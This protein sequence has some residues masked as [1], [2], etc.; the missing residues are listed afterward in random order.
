MNLYLDEYNS[1]V[2]SSGR[3]ISHIRDINDFFNDNSNSSS[4]INNKMP[5]PGSGGV[6]NTMGGGTGMIVGVNN[7]MRLRS[8]STVSEKNLR[9]KSH[10]ML[11]LDH[12]KASTLRRLSSSTSQQQSQQQQQQHHQQQQL[13]QQRHD[14]PVQTIRQQQAANMIDPMAAGANKMFDLP[15]GGAARVNSTTC[16]RRRYRD[17]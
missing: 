14:V 12:N 8:P 4:D 15:P 16:Q 9:C 2:Y 11:Y 3:T 1:S 6:G 17:S 7:S 13:Q 10:D 5:P